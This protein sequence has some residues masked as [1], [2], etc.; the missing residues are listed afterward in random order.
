MSCLPDQ[1][2]LPP[3]FAVD[4]YWLPLGAGEASPLVR[5]SGRAFEFV[6][7][8]RERRS[9]QRLF[10]SALQVHLYGVG[11]VIEM[12]P[13]WGQT[14]E[15][16][17]VVGEGPVGAR[18][19][20]RSRFFRYEVRRWAHGVI[21]DLAESE[22]SPQRLSSDEMHARRVLDLVPDFP[23]STWGRDDLSAG[24]MWNSNS[25]TS[26]LLARSG[27]RTDALVPPDGGR[28]PGW[29]AGLAVAERQSAARRVAE[30]PR[31]ASASPV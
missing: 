15:H 12:T 22:E 8:R 4:L 23:A 2:P 7:S 31:S 27:H 18:A 21:I 5:W 14:P 29:S 17:G 26:W 10:H 11:H 20:G 19:L 30:A 24:E 9:P 3:E 1:G 16:R 13:V 28:A 6:T 25:L